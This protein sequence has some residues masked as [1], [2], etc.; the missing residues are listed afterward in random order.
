MIKCTI[1]NFFE[2]GLIWGGP[3]DIYISIFFFGLIFSNSIHTI[4]TNEYITARSGHSHT[5]DR[6]PS[7]G[8]EIRR[9]QEQIMGYKARRGR[10][11]RKWGKEH[12][13]DKHKWRED[14]SIVIAW[15]PT[16]C[17]SPGYPQ[18]K[19]LRLGVRLSPDP[20]KT[21]QCKEITT[22]ELCNFDIFFRKKEKKD[23]FLTKTSK[24]SSG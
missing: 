21:Q 10:R 12:W 9:F 15:S 13:Q 18:K 3:A 16:T 4:T 8:I 24:E 20:S 6:S 14:A 17:V 11:G 5:L 7:I 2:H 1:N 23:L 19:G 22:Y